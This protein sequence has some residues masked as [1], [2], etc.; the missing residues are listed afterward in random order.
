MLQGQVAPLLPLLRV[1]TQIHLGEQTSF[2]LGRIEC[3]DGD[4]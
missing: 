2:G 1:A 4:A 3:E